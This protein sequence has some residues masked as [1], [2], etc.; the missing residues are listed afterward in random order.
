M[1]HLKWTE[2]PGFDAHSPSESVQFGSAEPK[3]TARQGSHPTSLPK[4][5]CAIWPAK[6]GGSCT[7]CGGSCA[8]RRAFA[9]TISRQ[10]S[11]PAPQ[12]LPPHAHT[13]PA[14]IELRR[15][16]RRPESARSTPW[17]G[18]LLRRRVPPG[19]G[20]GRQSRS[21]SAAL[22]SAAQLQLQLAPRPLSPIGRMLVARTAA[23]R[24]CGSPWA[25]ATRTSGGRRGTP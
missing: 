13:G 19:V 5:N 25:A 6:G 17:A 18:D 15:L 10:V 11:V 21:A 8:L 24:A 4:G 2:S 23:S 20:T 1:R 9:G 22:D 7:L 3:S 12:I 14:T 16:G